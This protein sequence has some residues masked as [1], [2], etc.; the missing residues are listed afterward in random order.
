MTIECFLEICKI[1][2]KGMEITSKVML[3]VERGRKVCVCE[4]SKHGR[5]LE[6]DSD[7]KALKFLLLESIK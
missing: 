3:D 1:G 5:Q 4:V 2:L 6:H 7:V